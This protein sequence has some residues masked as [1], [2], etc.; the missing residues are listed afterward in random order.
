M[1][2]KRFAFW[3]MFTWP[4]IFLPLIFIKVW[5]DRIFGAEWNARHGETF[6]TIYGITGALLV[7]ALVLGG[8]LGPM[9][10]FFG[11][12]P[13]ERRIR[14]SGRP[15]RAT[16]IAV[17]ENAGGGVVT[18][19]DQPYLNLVLRVEDG[20]RA[21]YETSVDAIIP[22]TAVPQFQPGAVVPVKVDPKDPKRVVLEY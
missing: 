21:A 3:A 4:V 6:I 20:M 17:G 2:K 12:G 8:T 15:A 1:A 13:T 11:G 22:R 7:A 5:G 10:S 16:I 9:L 14:A 19:N 18:V